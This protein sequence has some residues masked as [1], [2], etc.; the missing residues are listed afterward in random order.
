MMEDENTCEL[1]GERP[2][3]LYECEGLLVCDPCCHKH[4]AK[5]AEYADFID[6]DVRG[7]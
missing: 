3:E 6:D 1:C 2:E 7:S 5:L 4:A